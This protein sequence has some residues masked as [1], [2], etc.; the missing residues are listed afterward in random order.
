M[1]KYI[2]IL[3]CGIVFFVSSLAFSSPVNPKEWVIFAKTYGTEQ[4]N[5]NF[6][7]DPEFFSLIETL[8]GGKHFFAN[9]VTEGVHYSIEVFPTEDEDFLNGYLGSLQ[10]QKEIEILNSSFTKISSNDGLDVSY[11]DHSTSM[12]KKSRAI[13][14]KKNTY[15]L[16]TLYKE[17]EKEDHTYFI[18]SFSTVG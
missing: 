3:I 8:S 13:V 18:T 2:K 14:T 16:N 1:M 5:V 17:G 9:S 6:P 10:D 4:F 7:D 11:I 15:I 12:H